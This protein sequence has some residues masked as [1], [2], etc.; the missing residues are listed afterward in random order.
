NVKHRLG[1]FELE[2]AF[3]SGPGITALF[4]RSG[5]GKTSL[6]NIIAGLARPLS[7]RIAVDGV[8]LVDTARGIFVPKHKRRIGYV[9]QEG[10]LFPHLTV[11]HNLLFGR[12]FNPK[13]EK[14]ASIGDVTSLLGI[15][16]L[17]DRRPAALSG[18][19]KQRV[20]IGRA[21]LAN[22]RLLLMDEPLASLDAQRKDEIMPYIERL[23]D[24]TRIPIVYV[25]H[26][27][28]EVARLATTMVLMSNGRVDAVGP[29]AELLGRLDLAPMT[30]G[31]EAGA[32][33]DTI[34]AGQDE[35]Y[36][37]TRLRCAAGEIAVPRLDLPEGAPVRIRIRARDVI[38]ALAPPRGISALNVLPGRIAEIGAE[39]GGVRDLSI[40][41]A[42]G[43]LIA[44]V[45]QRSL[46][47]L[48]LVPGR[49]IFAVIKS[50]AL[51]RG[52]LGEGRSNGDFA[53]PLET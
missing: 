53:D 50:V 24:E 40:A 22:P 33:L 52:S 10:R 46:T 44:R 32:A 21:L 2:I 42:E 47:E 38:I 49:Q 12:W 19:E 16:P 11:R 20:A 41:L 18:G 27:V 31:A 34:V 43:R 39:S 6:V 25:S 5:A 48:N 30:G 17:L 8:E 37:L 45:T 7:G 51:D 9:F 1:R 23:R 29:V 36:G 15:E 28:A 35:R 3:E 13:P 26:S 4:G 14:P